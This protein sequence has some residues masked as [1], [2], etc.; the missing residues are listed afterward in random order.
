VIDIYEAEYDD[1]YDVAELIVGSFGREALGQIPSLGDA[2]DGSRMMFVRDYLLKIERKKPFICYI[3]KK[4]KELIGATAGYTYLH[5]W[6]P[7]LWGQEDFW[8]VKKEYR[9]DSVG[10]KL[11]EKLMGWFIKCKV[12]KVMMNHFSWNKK[13]GEFY[14]KNGFDH[15]ESSYVKDMKGEI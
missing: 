9:S 8:Y 13:V 5:R 3:A 7:Q 12:D 6:I 2:K 10:I 1:I 11:F 4:D 14:K 15:Y